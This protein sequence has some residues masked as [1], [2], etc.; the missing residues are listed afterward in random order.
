MKQKTEADHY[1]FPDILWLRMHE[2]KEQ[3]LKFENRLI[4]PFVLEI[5][6]HVHDTTSYVRP[7]DVGI[8][9]KSDCAVR[10]ADSALSLI[11]C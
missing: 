11:N 5:L 3:Q 7:R 2:T 10:S 8:E 9:F 1:D 4:G 6:S